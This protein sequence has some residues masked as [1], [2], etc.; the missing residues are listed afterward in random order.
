MGRGKGIYGSSWSQ[1][2]RGRQKKK[3]NQGSTSCLR[4]VNFGRGPRKGEGEHKTSPKK[5]RGSKEGLV[6]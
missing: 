4:G 2:V 3:K 6:P 5:K 1:G